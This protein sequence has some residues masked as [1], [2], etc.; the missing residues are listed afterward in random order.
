MDT[1]G[2][3]AQHYAHSDLTG[4]VL[5]AL[6]DAGRDLD[7]LTTADLAPIDEFHLGWL[8]Q[9][10]DFA[11]RLA[12]APGTRILDVGSGVGGPARHFAEVYGCTVTGV[13]ITPDFVEVSN[14]L[15][16][17]LGLA[18]RAT[19]VVGSA[20]NLPFGD[21]SFDAATLMHVGMNIA[22]K[23]RLFAEVRRVLQ[24]GGTFA[25]YEVMRT[26]EGPLP[27]PLPWADTMATSF[28]ETPDTY[29]SLLAEAGFD[30]GE[31]RDRTDF[32][33]EIGARM[34]ARTA[35]EGP[36]RLGLHVLMGPSAGE[37]MGRLAACLEQRLF[38]PLEMIATAR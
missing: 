3:V 24:P 38:A 10:L 6:R 7:A 29:R 26:G 17:R 25:V 5:A 31:E 16:A 32:V 11:R 15:T 19:F 33:L 12:F 14:V 4:T 28:V 8:P 18:G 22:D 36:P 27:L 1:E 13:D 37:K 9:T 34:R 20:L 30:L 35:A 21:T 2:E 23:A